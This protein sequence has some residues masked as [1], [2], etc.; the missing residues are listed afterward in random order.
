MT[1]IAAARGYDLAGHVAAQLNVD[2]L[3][4]ADDVLVMDADNIASSSSATPT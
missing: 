4:W 3:A 1:R 2:D